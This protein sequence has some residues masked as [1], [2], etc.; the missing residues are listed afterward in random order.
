MA[1][2]STHPTAAPGRHSLGLTNLQPRDDGTTHRAWELVMT[3]CN[4]LL[5]PFAT[6]MLLASSMPCGASAADAVRAA[7]LGH[8]KPLP[9]GYT[10]RDWTLADSRCPTVLASSAT[11]PTAWSNSKAFAKHFRTCRTPSTARSPR[12]I[13]SLCTGNRVGPTPAGPGFP[14]K[15]QAVVRM[16]D[17]RLAEELTFGDSLGRMKPLGMLPT[18]ATGSATGG[19][20]GDGTAR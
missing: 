17:G 18:P 11:A 16:A 14:M 9:A 3:H 19:S 2:A 5:S 7:S 20:G 8:N 13:W 10:R 12:T 6:V 15:V 1:A 4:I